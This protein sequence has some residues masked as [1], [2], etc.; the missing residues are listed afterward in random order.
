MAAL[1][2]WLTRI[3]AQ[4]TFTDV[5]DLAQYGLEEPSNV[6][7]WET[8]QGS[9]TYHVGDYNSLGSVYYICEPESRKVYAVTASLGTGFGYSLEELTEEK[10]E[11][12]EQSDGAESADSQPAA[13]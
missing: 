7:H 10:A 11:S 1:G 5:T 4:N 8:A 2:G 3:V 9:Y 12:T 13:E 6:L